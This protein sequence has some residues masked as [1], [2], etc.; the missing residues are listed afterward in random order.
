MI[1]SI[2]PNLMVESV[3]ET[4]S[5][6]KDVLGFSVIDSVEN[7]G[8]LDFAILMNNGLIIM[9]QRKESLIEEYPVLETEKIKPCLS[10]YMKTNN[11]EGLYKKIK[12]KVKILKDIHTNFYNIKEF[13]ITDNNGY[14]IT[15]AE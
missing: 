6:Y 11:I 10:L 14:V 9:F 8:I 1:N 12:L 13:A 2:T 7:D 5:F 4:I 3:E 15:I